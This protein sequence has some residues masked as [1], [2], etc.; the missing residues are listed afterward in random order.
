MTYLLLK[1]IHI[2]SAI[3]LFGTGFGS[4]FYKWMA[5]RSGNL[6]HIAVVNRHVVLADWLFTTPT[7][8]I[9]PM[10]GFA[11]ASMAGW[12]LSSAWLWLSISLYVLAGLCWLPV[13]YLQ[14][15]MRALSNQAVAQ[16]Q[17]LPHRYQQYAR[18]WFFLGIIAFSAMLAVVYLMISKGAGL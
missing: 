16:Q 5:D 18:L 14:I 15:R 11:L 1:Y 9:Q 12:S 3:V 7:V 10:T 17:A 6:A 2:L 4:A 8:I 13:V